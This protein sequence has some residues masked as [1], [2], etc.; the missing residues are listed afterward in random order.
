M[1]RQHA[2]IKFED[3]PISYKYMDQIWPWNTGLCVE[4]C[5][6]DWFLPSFKPLA[7]RRVKIIKEKDTCFVN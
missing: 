6:Q 1:A 2:L 4:H 7:H 3:I 5:H